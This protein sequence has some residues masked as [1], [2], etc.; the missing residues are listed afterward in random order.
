MT[1]RGS[2]AG[3]GAAAAGVIALF[4]LLAGEASAVETTAVGSVPGTYVSVADLSSENW[5]RFGGEGIRVGGFLLLGSV[6]TAVT[7]DDNVFASSARDEEDP[8]YNASSDA[9]LLSQWSRHRLD[10]VVGGD[11]DFYGSESGENRGYFHTGVSGELEVLH[12]LSLFGYAKYRTGKEERGTGDSFLLFDAPI[13]YGAFDAGVSV[14][15]QFNRLWTTF[16]GS[17]RS[18]DYED[19]R[20]R[21]DTFDQDFRDSETYDIFT[22]LGYDLSIKT[23]IYAEAGYTRADYGN[24]FFDGDGYRLLGG[25]KYELN[26]LV[27]ADVAA[28]FLRHDYDSTEVGDLDTFTYRGQVFWSPTPLLDVAFVG[29]RDVGISSF[30]GASSRLSSKAGIRVDYAFWRNLRLTGL[31]SH[32]WIDYDTLDAE[33]RAFELG[34]GAEYFFNPRWSV[35]VDVLHR[36]Y[37]S[38]ISDADYERDR[39]TVGSKWRY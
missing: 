20:F 4:G 5:G 23:S 25:V 18:E 27:T 19:A 37:E 12:D 38:A 28:G 16:G 3:S 6:G 29:A 24:D 10:F 21:A 2:L 39:V 1:F 32:E 14:Q 34:A 31:A 22:Q 15:K 7:F 26:Q 35:S 33:D 8:Y 17:F 11:G 9:R 13:E 36:D 30:A